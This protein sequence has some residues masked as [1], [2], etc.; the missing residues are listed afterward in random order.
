MAK[1]EAS[2]HQ[3]EKWLSLVKQVETLLETLYETN[4]KIHEFSVCVCVREREGEG[5]EG[6][7]SFQKNAAETCRR[8]DKARK[9]PFTTFHTFHTFHSLQWNLRFEQESLTGV[10]GQ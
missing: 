9:P 2:E 6:S 1:F 3:E 10:K 8:N 4:R 5:E 7:S